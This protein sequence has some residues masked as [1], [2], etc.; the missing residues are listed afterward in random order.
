[1]IPCSL[2][3]YCSRAQATPHPGTLPHPSSAAMGLFPPPGAPHEP[4]FDNP[5][6]WQKRILISFILAA[7][8]GISVAMCICPP[9]ENVLSDYV[10]GGR[11]ETEVDGVTVSAADTA[12]V[13]FSSALVFIMIP[14]IAFFYGGMI[15]HKNVVGTIATAILPLAIIPLLWA[16]FGFSLAFGKNTL[17]GLI[18][19]PGTYGLMYNVGHLPWGELPIS[20]TTMWI[21]QC[22]FATLTPAILIG[23]IADRVNFAAL[24]VFV[25]LW[26]LA[27]YCPVAHW[28]WGGGIISSYGILD[29]A[30]GMVVHMSSGYSALAA[31]YFLGPS[32]KGPSTEGPANIPYTV[33]GTSLLWF[34]WYGFNGGS[35]FGASAYAAHAMVNTTIA[36]AC[37]MLV[38]LMMDQIKGKSFKTTGMCLGIVVGLVGITPACG[39][40]NFGAAGIIGIAASVIC[41]LAQSAMEKWGKAKA[42]DTLDV[43]ACH[44]IGGTVGMVLTSCFQSRK[45]GAWDYL[46]GAFYGMP[47]E[48]GKC[49]I[50]LV[51]IVAY[52][53]LATYCIMWFVNCF[54]S[55]RVTEEEEDEGLDFSKHFEGSVTADDA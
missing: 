35:A 25:P 43:F 3:T 51:C 26:H 13:L 42:D 53:L 4:A 19:S 44:G 18:G 10:D 28:V 22:M 11:P 8:L 46:D 40:V 9:G 31:A 6:P 24:C 20:T 39:I 54:I 37:S 50:V 45:A 49:L 52:F 23:S 2:L 15:D 16:F 47:E 14:G 17:A 27:V 41:S 21:F 12:W 1:M 30:G 33:L 38:W 36:T 32:V 48:L 29:F 34:G 5:S 7:V 55:M